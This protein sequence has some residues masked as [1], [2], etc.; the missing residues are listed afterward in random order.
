M[1]PAGYTHA[2]NPAE[3]HGQDVGNPARGIQELGLREDDMGMLR[4]YGH[5]ARI[6]FIKPQVP[7]NSDSDL[8]CRYMQDT[9]TLCNKDI[10]RKA[11]AAIGERAGNSGRKSKVVRD[12]CNDERKG[13]NC[14]WRRSNGWLCGRVL[15]ASGF[16]VGDCVQLEHWITVRSIH[17]S[18]SLRSWWCKLSQLSNRAVSTASLAASGTLFVRG[19]ISGGVLGGNNA[20][21][22]A[23]LAA[24]LAA[25][26]TLVVGGNVGS[27]SLGGGGEGDDGEGVHLDWVV[28]W[29]VGR[30]GS[31]GGNV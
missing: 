10:I 19:D 13:L 7:R 5:E 22:A 24:A 18:V 28:G 17:I 6:K 2:E 31:L 3:W 9:Y 14:G 15:I 16:R 29:E 26:G 4:G 25:A 20:V 23:A 1:R 12:A 27:G 8:V 30:D 11:N 21:A